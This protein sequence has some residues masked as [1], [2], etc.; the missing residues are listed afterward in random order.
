MS[1]VSYIWFKNLFAFLFQSGGSD[2][3]FQWRN[4]IISKREQSASNIREETKI[5]RKFL[6]KFFFNFSPKIKCI[7]FDKADQNKKQFDKEFINSWL[8]SIWLPISCQI[9][10]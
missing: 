2:R 3:V 1:K 5:R 7:K 6:V 8:V 9:K 10:N 4:Q